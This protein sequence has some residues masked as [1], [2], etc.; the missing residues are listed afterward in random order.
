MAQAF[1]RGRAAFH[2]VFRVFKVVL[3]ACQILFGARHIGVIAGHV[4]AGNKLALTDGVTF[5][6]E[7]LGDLA[8]GLSP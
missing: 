8:G 6:D 7:H 5:V 1:V 3:R 4:K 2:K